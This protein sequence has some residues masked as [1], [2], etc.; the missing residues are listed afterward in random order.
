MLLTQLDAMRK[1][2]KRRNLLLD[3]VRKSYLRDVVVVN[4]RL[5]ELE[6]TN[7]AKKREFD[8]ISLDLRPTRFGPRIHRKAP[9]PPRERERERERETDACF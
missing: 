2:L 4:E 1:R 8:A 7:P 6:A 3:E 5:K 9:C